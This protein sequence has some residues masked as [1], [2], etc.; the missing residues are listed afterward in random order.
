MIKHRLIR[1]YRLL[2]TSIVTPASPTSTLPLERGSYD[3]DHLDQ[4]F[5]LDTVERRSKRIGGLADCQA[6][7]KENFLGGDTVANVTVLHVD[8]FVALVN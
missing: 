3:S 8:V 1:N 4:S 6:V 7:S 5:V 2:L